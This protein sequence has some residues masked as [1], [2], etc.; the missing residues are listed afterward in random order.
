MF[1]FGSRARVHEFLQRRYY[2]LLA[3]M[4]AESLD[5]PTTRA[6]LCKKLLTISGEEPMTMRAL[7]VVSKDVVLGQSADGWLSAKS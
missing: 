5:N 1:D 7:D 4:E 2:D 3:E 6:L